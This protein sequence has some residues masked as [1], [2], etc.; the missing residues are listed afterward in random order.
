MKEKYT[1][2][3]VGKSKIAVEEI[4]ADIRRSQRKHEIRAILAE[5]PQERVKELLAAKEEARF[6]SYFLS[7][8]GYGDHIAYSHNNWQAYCPEDFDSYTFFED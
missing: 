3:S 6:I 7:H 2:H 4:V 5:T 1:K 8:S